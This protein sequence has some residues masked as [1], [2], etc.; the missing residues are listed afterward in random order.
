ML[1]YSSCVMSSA[2]RRYSSGCPALSARVSLQPGDKTQSPDLARDWPAAG[3][4]SLRQGG[5][6]QHDDPLGVRTVCMYKC[7][8]M[9]SL[10][11]P[12]EI[13][14]ILFFSQILFFPLSF[15]GVWRSPCFSPRL[16]TKHGFQQTEF[17]MQRHLTHRS[18]LETAPFCILGGVT[19]W[20]H[21]SVLFRA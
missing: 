4:F 13:H 17:V 14:F 11:V 5:V 9:V 10:K 21:N 3:A 2:V 20:V 7:Y 18:H 19:N 16:E 8:V 1:L 15:I 6:S 12:Y